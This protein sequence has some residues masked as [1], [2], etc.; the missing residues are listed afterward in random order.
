LCVIGLEVSLKRN[1]VCETETAEFLEFLR[2]ACCGM[3]AVNGGCCV[4][5]TVRSTLVTNDMHCLLPV[6]RRGMFVPCDLPV[7]PVQH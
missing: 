1:K 5:L 6:Y 7:K 4:I 2:E 3:C